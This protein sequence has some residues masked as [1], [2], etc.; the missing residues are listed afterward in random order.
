MKLG[1]LFKIKVVLRKFLMN[2]FMS[3]AKSVTILTGEINLRNLTLRN[4]NYL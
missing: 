1:L 2:Y 3:S 4:E